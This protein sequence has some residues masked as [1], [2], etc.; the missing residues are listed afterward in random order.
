V[1]MRRSG[2]QLGSST[3]IST[4]RC[5]WNIE[6]RAMEPRGTVPMVDTRDS[7]RFELPLLDGERGDEEV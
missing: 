1:V 3:L 6:L 2:P 7:G 5:R 4:V